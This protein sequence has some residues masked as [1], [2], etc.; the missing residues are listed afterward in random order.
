MTSMRPQR[1]RRMPSRAPRGSLRGHPRGSA[2][3]G[4]C[5]RGLAGHAGRGS[6]AGAP[7][8]ALWAPRRSSAQ[9]AGAERGGVVWGYH[10]TCF[11]L[12]K[13]AG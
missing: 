1:A 10:E 7:V 5:R 6:A 9:V 3:P 13:G 2:T 12:P 11:F 8:V 4:G